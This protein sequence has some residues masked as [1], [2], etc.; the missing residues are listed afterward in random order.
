M[1]SSIRRDSVAASLLLSLLVALAAFVSSGIAAHAQGNPPPVKW[2]AVNPT[3]K[4]KAGEVVKLQVRATIPNGWHL[5]SPNNDVA[6]PMEITAGESKVVATMGTPSYSPKP[7]R[8]YDSNLDGN[9]E[10]WEHTVTITV[11]VTLAANLTDGDHPAWVNF[12]HQYCNATNGMCALPKDAKIAFTIHVGGDETTADHAVGDATDPKVL[13][14]H[15]RDSVREY[16][17]SVAAE[18]QALADSIKGART[19]SLAAATGVD[20]AGGTTADV[21]TPP[22]GGR[23]SE[24]APGGHVDEITE[25]RNEGFGAFL[26]LAAGAGLFALMTP[27]VF[28]MIPITVS[29]F[30]KRSEDHRSRTVRDALFYSLGI[31]STFSLLGLA[32]AL[33]LGATGINDVA[34]NPIMNLVIAAVFVIFALSLFGMYEI[35]VPTKLLNT[36]N[37]KAQGDGVGSIMLMGL[38]FS[39][40]SF[41]C[42]V[43]FIGGLM[44]TASTGN[45]LWPLA[46]AAMFAAVFSAPFFLLAMFPALL[47]KMPKSGGWLNSVKVVMGFLEIAFAIKF[48]SNADLIWS[49][50]VLTRD[51]FLAIWVAI[52]VIVTI[53]LLGKF[54]LPH[55]SETSKIGP[56][57]LLFSTAFLAIGFWLFTGL[58]GRNLGEVD[59]FLPPSVYPGTETASIVTT[60]PTSSDAES[61]WILND[62]PRALTVAQKSGKPIFID[63]TGYTCTNCR[64]MEK[65]M[66][67]RRDVQELMGKYVLARLYTDR[68]DSIDRAQQRMLVEDYKTTALPY[69]VILSSDGTVIDRRAFTRDA[70][71]FTSFLRGGLAPG[72]LAS[73]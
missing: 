71:E 22:G 28:P 62:Y 23:S 34:T 31:I 68:R 53:Y 27:C 11:P 1:K 17:D 24:V 6:L 3:V 63:F 50:G 56:I 44:A 52:A 32:L 21:A 33:L 69:Y 4:A 45:W 36:L 40:T 14:Q 47:K 42:T 66:F 25:A 64:W 60:D 18:A 43:P 39:L 19:D 55:D 67:P 61:E 37:M 38:V 9:T 65:N 73:R 57:R 51:A 29:F 46:G 41:T 7:T 54:H 20:T 59:A 58:L 16:R 72:T 26:W 13:E 30:T 2:S 48:L 5:Y 70:E 8:H 10:Y 49:W 12:Y 35:Q 15:R